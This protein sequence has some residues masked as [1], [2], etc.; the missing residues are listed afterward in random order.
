V[1]GH[2]DR[3]LSQFGDPVN[4]FMNVAS[5][6]EE[7]VFG[8]QMEVRKFGHGYLDFSRGDAPGSPGII[9]ATLSHEEKA[10]QTPTSVDILM[11]NDLELQGRRHQGAL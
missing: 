3:G 2:G 10:T 6:V 9:E 5:A 4:E 11:A 8:M 1:I 7:G